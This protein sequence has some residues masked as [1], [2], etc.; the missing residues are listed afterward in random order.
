VELQLGDLL[1]PCAKRPANGCDPAASRWARSRLARWARR[2]APPRASHRFCR[3]RARGEGRGGESGVSEAALPRSE[4]LERRPLGATI[5]FV[6]MVAMWAGFFA[7]LVADRIDGVWSWVR[8]L[9]LLA[10]LVLW[11]ALFPWFLGAAVWTSSWTGWLRLLL[12]LGFAFG[13]SLASIPRRKPP[14][15]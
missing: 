12:V 5:W 9:P 3:A 1:A 6:W 11:L 10:E 2:C 4:G 14:K 13:W 8:D 15:Q 7:F